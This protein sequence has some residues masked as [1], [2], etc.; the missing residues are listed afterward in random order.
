VRCFCARVVL[1]TYLKDKL[2]S[3][4]RKEACVAVGRA[5]IFGNSSAVFLYFGSM[6]LLISSQDHFKYLNGCLDASPNRVVIASYGLYA[7]ILPDGRDV[8]TFGKKFQSQTR[9]L[10]ERMRAVHRVQMLIGLYEFKSCKGKLPCADC[11]KK[12]ALDLIRH[13][14]H[15]EAF[16]EFEWKVTN[17]SHI[18]C[19][20]FYGD[21]DYCAGVAGSRNFTDSSWEDVSVTLDHDGVAGLTKHI[22][23]IWNQSRPLCGDTINKV[24]K[25]Q[26]ISE[27][28]LA[29]ITAGI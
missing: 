28:A 10:M 17:S 13:L 19:A 16:P 27:G 22:D 20:L 24:L 8:T 29:K 23:T 14:N 15:A 5:G 12:Y 25:E 6:K 9:D 21:F 2:G 7:G 26:N 11:E 3:L 4:N 1:Q 18:K